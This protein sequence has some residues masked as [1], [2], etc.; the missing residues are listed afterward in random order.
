M[1]QQNNRPESKEETNNG[2][3]TKDLNRPS[4]Q[5]IQETFE[6]KEAKI[7]KGFNKTLKELGE[8]L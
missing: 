5:K 1:N 7:T 6:E 2:K 8:I 4:E 3:S